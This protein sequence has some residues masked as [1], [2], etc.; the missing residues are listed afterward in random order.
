MSVSSRPLPALFETASPTISP[1]ILYPPLVGVHVECIYIEV[2]SGELE[3]GKH[4][5]QG[6]VLAIPMGDKQAIEKNGF[7]KI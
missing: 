5:L 6:Q 4:L 7:T 3:G 2:I 1:S